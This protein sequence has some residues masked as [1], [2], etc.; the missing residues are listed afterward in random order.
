MIS[1]KSKILSAN[2][3]SA[4]L[5]VVKILWEISTLFLHAPFKMAD[6]TMYMYVTIVTDQHFLS[7]VPRP[8]PFLPSV[9]VHINTREQ[10]TGPLLPSIMWMQTEGTNGTGQYFPHL[11]VASPLIWH[12]TMQTW[13]LRKEGLYSWPM[14]LKQLLAERNSLSKQLTASKLD[15]S[16]LEGKLQVRVLC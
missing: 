12:N 5:N 6:V 4:T 9:C 2:G 11:V 16:K 1:Y 8:P 7:F 15:I 14:Q 13:L 10:R 3:R